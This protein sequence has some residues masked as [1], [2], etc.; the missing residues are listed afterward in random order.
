MKICEAMHVPENNLFGQHDHTIEFIDSFR[1]SASFLV[2]H[3]Y[4]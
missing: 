2:L 3:N 1:F 4:L